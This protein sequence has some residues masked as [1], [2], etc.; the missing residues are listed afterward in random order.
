M[1]RKRSAKNPFSAIN[2]RL[3]RLGSAITVLA[4][5]GK[6]KNRHQLVQAGCSR[7]GVGTEFRPDESCIMRLSDLTRRVTTNRRTGKRMGPPLSCGCIKREC[8][9]SFYQSRK[10]SGPLQ[11]V[12]KWVPNQFWEAL[13]DKGWGSGMRICALAL[14]KGG[15]RPAIPMQLTREL[16]QAA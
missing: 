4:D 1:S 3:K 16:A 8:C 2:R 7:C 6:D 11:V 5:A 12:R 10:R 14:R 13:S 9:Q 15:F